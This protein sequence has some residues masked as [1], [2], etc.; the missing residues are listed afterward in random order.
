MGYQQV[1]LFLRGNAAAR[2]KGEGE[3]EEKT[4]PG[5]ECK[6]EVVRA[7]TVVVEGEPDTVV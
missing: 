1:F 2:V 5:S 6:F 7:K 3:G 4:Y